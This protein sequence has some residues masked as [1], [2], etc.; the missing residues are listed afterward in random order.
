MKNKFFKSLL[1][2]VCCSVLFSV[3]SFASSLEHDN[4]YL[5]N[6]ISERQNDTA[7][8]FVLNLGSEFEELQG[9]YRLD[10]AKTFDC[11]VHSINPEAFYICDDGTEL[12]IYIASGKNSCGYSFNACFGLDSNELN[13]IGIN[14]STLSIDNDGY[15]VSK[16]NDKTL[17]WHRLDKWH[18][19][20]LINENPANAVYFD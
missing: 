6:L 20:T 18:G 17:Y 3:G 2:G 7:F 11:A 19:I 10:L 12:Y 14:P 5:T 8:E 1:L 16:E 9:Y 4:N 13:S 15:L